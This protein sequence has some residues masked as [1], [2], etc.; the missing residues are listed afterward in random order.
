MSEETWLPVEVG[1]IKK[2]LQGYPV[3]PK[4]TWSNKY[5]IWNTGDWEDHFTMYHCQLVE[6]VID[7]N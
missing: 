5:A 7:Q 3:N 4:Y 1:Y 2:S 6:L